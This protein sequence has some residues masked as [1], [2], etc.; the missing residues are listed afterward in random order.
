MGL[1]LRAECIFDGA[2]IAGFLDCD[3]GRFDNPNDVAL[4]FSHA[5]IGFWCDLTGS[6]RATGSVLGQDEKISGRFDCSDAFFD[7]TGEKQFIS[8]EPRLMAT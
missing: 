2:K 5:K 8:M 3:D 1:A 7:G 4:S 6:F